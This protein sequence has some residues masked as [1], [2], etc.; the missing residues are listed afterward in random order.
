MPHRPAVYADLLP[1][2]KLLAAAFH[3]DYLFGEFIH[4]HRNEYP[5]DAY[6]YYLRWLRE[7]YYSEPGEYLIVTY[8]TI[9]ETSKEDHITG[10]AHWIRNY[11]KP[12]RASLISQAVV[13]AISVYN[14]AEDYIYPNRAIDY[15]HADVLPLG[16]P[17]FEHHW[18]GT[19]A[20]SWHLSLLGVHP[21]AMK[22]GYGRE[23]VAWGFDRS[24]EEG[25][26]VSVVSVP[27]Q[28]GFYR[29]CG[30]DVEVG[31]MND[32]GG[33]ANPHVAAGLE[34]APILF[35][36]HGMEPKGMKKYGEK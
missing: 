11:S 26:S 8:S 4:P 7:T 5:D 16:N 20:D 25:V 23:L 32:E 29:A 36:D 1:A 19:R 33:D 21:N 17:F 30:F 35:C 12:P 15:S 14:A 34:P 27:G 18:T 6:L 3:D 2:S 31:T 10:I 22:R 13:K 9:A 28:E 24:R